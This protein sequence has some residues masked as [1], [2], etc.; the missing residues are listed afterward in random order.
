LEIDFIFLLFKASS[1]II[2]G[3]IKIEG[4]EL[5]YPF[6]TRANSN[7]PLSVK[8]QFI[9]KKGHY[10]SF[11]NFEYQITEKIEMWSELNIILFAVVEAGDARVLKLERPIVIK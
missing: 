1:G 10:I 2:N 11:P 8:N 9:P 4:S 5:I 3:I 7:L 6:S